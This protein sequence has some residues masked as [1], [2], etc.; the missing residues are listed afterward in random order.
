MNQITNGTDEIDNPNGFNPMTENISE[1]WTINLRLLDDTMTTGRYNILL[2]KEQYEKFVNGEA[3]YF[4]VKLRKQPFHYR[5]FGIFK[6]RYYKLVKINP[7][8]REAT[9]EEIPD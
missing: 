1:L 3:E 7:I 5:I 2:T 9:Y 6:H 8:L 4:S